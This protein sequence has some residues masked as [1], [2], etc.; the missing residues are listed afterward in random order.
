M[1]KFRQNEG[2]FTFSM[3]AEK[4]RRE[5]M[6]EMGG[7]KWGKNR[8]KMVE[9]DVFLPFCFTLRETSRHVGPVL[10]KADDALRAWLAP[11]AL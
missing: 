4:M 9:F 8:A 6:V 1:S 3:G 10:A 7:L 2:F 5:L 11:S